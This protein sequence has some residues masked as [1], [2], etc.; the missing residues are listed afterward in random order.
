MLRWRREVP[1][2]I[3]SITECLTSISTGRIVLYL[4]CVCVTSTQWLF[5][6]RTVRCWHLVRGRTKY[7]RAA[8]WRCEGRH[9]IVSTYGT[10]DTVWLSSSYSLAC[11]FVRTIRLS[12][13]CLSI[14]PQI[15]ILHFKINHPEFSSTE[16]NSRYATGGL[17]KKERKNEQT[18]KQT[19][20]NTQIAWKNTRI[21]NHQIK[22]EIFN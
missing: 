11:L 13:M 12:D 15:G 18:N 2:I 10:Y 6:K 16:L 7:L 17:H 3:I 8:C 1:V 14:R 21:L 4:Q 20:K 9:E 22:N 5:W 19:N